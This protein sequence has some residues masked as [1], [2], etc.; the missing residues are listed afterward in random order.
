M[1]IEGVSPEEYA[2][3][4]G[5]DPVYDQA[6]RNPGDGYIFYNFSSKCQART[7]DYL[8]S[9]AGAVGRTLAGK[10]GPKDRRGLG[11]L[12]QHVVALLSL[13][14][15]DD[16][17]RGYLEAALWAS[18][19]SDDH[20]APLDRDHHITDIEPESLASMTDDCARF[21]RDHAVLLAQ[22][23]EQYPQHH[24]SPQ[25]YAGHDLWLTRIGAGCGYL[26]GDLSK[27]V[28]DALTAAARNLG[29]TPELYVGDDKRIYC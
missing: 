25:A 13:T 17:T 3:Y 27:D 24:C 15:L 4:W 18:T 21:Q 16:F 7:P 10:L 2:A 20:D 11:L 14:K 5:C 19:D 9:F 8:E 23:Y 26:D 12:L 22:A 1:K 28:G 6:P 29:G